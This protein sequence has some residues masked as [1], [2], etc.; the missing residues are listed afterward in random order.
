MDLLKVCIVGY[1][2]D[3]MNFSSID[4]LKDAIHRDIELTKLELAKPE[5]VNLRNHPFFNSNSTN[6]ETNHVNG[7][8][9]NGDSK[10]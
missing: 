7:C 9:Q 8:P 10:L 4:E 2:R 5:V 6:G 3:E 1:I